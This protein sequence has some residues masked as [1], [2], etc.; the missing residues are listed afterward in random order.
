V[1]RYRNTDPV[2]ASYLVRLGAEKLGQNYHAFPQ[3]VLFD[4]IGIRNAIIETDPYGNFLGQGYEMVAARDW[5]RLGN[6]YLQDGVWKANGCCPKA[7]SHV[8]LRAPRA[9]QTCIR[10]RVLLGQQT[11]GADRFRAFAYSMQGAGE[12]SATIIPTHDLVVVR[13]GSIAAPRPGTPRWAPRC[14]GS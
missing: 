11:C 14:T 1:G 9:R 4:K 5:A 8:D 6:L 13:L 10:R 3:R 7:R 12:V 2:L